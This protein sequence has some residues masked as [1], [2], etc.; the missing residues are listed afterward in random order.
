MAGAEVIEI[1]DEEI[2]E[3]AYEISQRP[4]AGTEEEN[5]L[6]AE[7]ELRSEGAPATKPA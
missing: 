6:R 4:D 2:R 7:Q 5:W 3:R 1:T